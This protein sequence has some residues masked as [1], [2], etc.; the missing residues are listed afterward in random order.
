LPSGQA[1]VKSRIRALPGVPDQKDLMNL[2]DPMERF[3]ATYARAA[4]LESFDASRCVLATATADGRP[5]ARFVLV[6][7]TDDRGFRFHTHYES[8]KGREL[9][10]NPRAALAFHWESI[11]EQVRV[12]GSV[13]RLEPELSDAYFAARPRGSQIGAWA[14]PQSEPIESREVLLARATRLER[15]FAGAPIPRPD[16]WGGY[17]LVPEAIEFWS[18]QADRLH[19]RVLYQKNGAAW[20]MRRIAP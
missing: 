12:E 18:N 7:E 9:G 20:T 5:S 15:Q 2:D 3:R 11:G 16:F 4:S 10:E 14:S 13:E 8:R 1:R 19:D 17:R 6:K